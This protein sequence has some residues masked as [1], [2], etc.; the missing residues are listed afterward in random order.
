MH[1]IHVNFTKEIIIR[2]LF[3]SG[4]VI[5]VNIQPDL[6]SVDIKQLLNGVEQDMRNY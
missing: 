6:V 2:Q 3:A 4:S 1:F 5:M